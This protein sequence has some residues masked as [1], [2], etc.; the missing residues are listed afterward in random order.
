LCDELA[1]AVNQISSTNLAIRLSVVSPSSAVMFTYLGINLA[2]VY[3]CFR[4]DGGVYWALSESAII[5]L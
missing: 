4:R 1:S 2:V 5:Y 3:P